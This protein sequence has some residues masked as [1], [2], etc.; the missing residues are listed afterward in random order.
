MENRFTSQSHVVTRRAEVNVVAEFLDVAV[1][2]PAALV[3]EGEPGIGKTTLWLDGVDQAHRRGFTVLTARAAMAESVLA[4]TALADL[5]SHVDDTIWA[6]LPVPQ[7]QGLD[8][9]LWPSQLAADTDRRAVAAAFSAVI[10]R[11]GAIGPIL[12]AIDDC[13]WLD[14]SSADVVA[15]VARRLPPG[16]ALLCTTRSDAAPMSLQLPRPDAVRR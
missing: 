13:Q 6:D 1:N 15:F 4:Y 11:L 8:A 16:V 7:R 14:S 12:I 3:I 2:E 10:G 9:V 5:L